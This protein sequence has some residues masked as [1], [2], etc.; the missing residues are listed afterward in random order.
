MTE[1]NEANEEMSVEEED[2]NNGIVTT[3]E[4]MQAYYT[5]KSVL[6]EYCDSNKISYKD[7]A[8]YFGILYDNKVTKWI[9]RV[10]LKDN[11]KFIIIP[12]NNKQEVR[13][14]L[15]SID[16]IYKLRKELFNRL[17]QFEK[18]KKKE[19]IEVL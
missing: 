8:S 10:Y 19:I 18:I 16:D 17:S 2:T 4:E 15:K 7:T 12:D 13:Y 9:C 3:V 14:D 1:N 5:V 11:V 6:A